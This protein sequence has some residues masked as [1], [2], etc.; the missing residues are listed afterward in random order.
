MPK[1]SRT[2]KAATAAFAATKTEQA[3]YNIFSVD[4]SP[5]EDGSWEVCYFVSG[6]ADL[7][8]VTSPLRGQALNDLI[9]AAYTKAGATAPDLEDEQS[10]NFYAIRA[11]S[12]TEAKQRAS[13]LVYI[14]QQAG[15]KPM[16]DE[17]GL[18]TPKAPAAASPAPG[19]PGAKGPKA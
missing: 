6:D 8:D 7:G 10:K 2:T 3:Y 14:F 4:P 15:L 5:E 19:K 13:E 18:H 16:N 17:T 11:G 12:E 1:P 9:K